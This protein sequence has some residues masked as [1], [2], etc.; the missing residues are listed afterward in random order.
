MDIGS[1]Y[2]RVP[3]EIRNA[4]WIVIAQKDSRE[5]ELF[6]VEDYNEPIQIGRKDIDALIMSYQNQKNK[7]KKQHCRQ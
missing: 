7:K 1:T 2:C 4:K 3:I 5:A 6:L